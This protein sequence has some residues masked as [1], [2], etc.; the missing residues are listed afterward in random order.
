MGQKWEPLRAVL[1][2]LDGTL[3]D[4]QPHFECILNELR[5]EQ[6]LG[7]LPPGF[8]KPWVNAGSEAMLR[9]A[10]GMPPLSSE[11]LIPQLKQRFLTSY[12][13][14]MEHQPA[15]LFAGIPQLL[16]ALEAHQIPWGIVTNKQEALAHLAVQSTALKAAA[17]LVGGDTLSYCKPHPAPILHALS[18]LKTAPQHSVFIGD[19]SSDI[20]AGQAAHTSTG[21]VEWG[22]TLTADLAAQE[23][24]DFTFQAPRQILDLVLQRRGLS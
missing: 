14:E 23:Q 9:A 18:F 4:T 16:E 5:R 24:P 8:I 20:R 10:F 22:Y 11:S 3:L 15:R 13:L 2:D 6:G 21:F 19:S 12:R 17:V 1:F 7:P